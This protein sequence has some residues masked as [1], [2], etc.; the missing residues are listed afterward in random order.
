MADIQDQSHQEQENSEYSSKRVKMRVI[1]DGLFASG[2]GS[3][4]RSAQVDVGTSESRRWNLREGTG[5][6]GSG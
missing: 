4:R 5:R 1:S 3:R 6:N 2:A